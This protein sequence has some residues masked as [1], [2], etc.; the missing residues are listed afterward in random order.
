MAL[1]I[2]NHHIHWW[3]RCGVFATI[4]PA[5]PRLI[6][7]NGVVLRFKPTVANVQ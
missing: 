5:R 4:N 7:V 1:V 6:T 2:G 3:K